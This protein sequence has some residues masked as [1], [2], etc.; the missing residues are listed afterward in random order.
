MLIL[1]SICFILISGLGLPAVF[2]YKIPKTNLW[3]YTDF[4]RTSPYDMSVLKYKEREMNSSMAT[5]QFLN[6]WIWNTG[7]SW[8]S[9]IS[10]ER[11]C[12]P[13]LKST[14]LYCLLCLPLPVKPG[15]FQLPGQTPA[16]K[17]SLDLDCLNKTQLLCLIYPFDSV[18]PQWYR[19]DGIVVCKLHLTYK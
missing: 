12:C 18:K 3:N 16:S 8:D 19:R 2:L 6:L 7:L 17:T 5:V 13:Q 15:I 1:F 9:V 11:D 4:F 14:P 10:Q